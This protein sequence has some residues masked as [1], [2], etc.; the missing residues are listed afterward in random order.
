V[1][2]YKGVLFDLGSTLI[3]FNGNWEQV[4]AGADNAVHTALLEAGYKFEGIDFERLYR[5][6][7]RAYH[8]Q[9]DIDLIEH[10]TIRILKDLMGELGY[11]DLPKNILDETMRRMYAVSQAHWH[12]EED[13]ADT[14]RELKERDYRIGIVS[15]AANEQDVDTLVDN[16]EIRPY[17]DFV[18]TSAAC[19]MRKPSPVIF[20][21]ALDLLGT[22]P[23]ET[24]LVG[25]LLRP[26]IFGAQQMEIFS[27]WITR[28][29]NNT[30]NQRLAE[31]ITPDAQ[32]AA[33]SELPGLLDRL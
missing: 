1:S 25:D 15:N 9:R 3:Y 4:F 19:G 29:A 33:L 17:L 12:A 6:R 30:E 31:T 8:A 10:T 20:R 26:D 11:P 7:L 27:V 13:A 32:I 5:E 23:D 21:K 28:R 22:A 14:L 18:L 2:A 16:A 24:V